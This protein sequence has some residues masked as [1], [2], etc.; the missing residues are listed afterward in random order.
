MILVDTALKKRAASGRP[1]LV[2]MA[3]AGFMGRGIASQIARHMPGLKLAAVY[4]RNPENARRACQEAGLSGIRAVEKLPDLRAA[5]ARGECAVTADAN[6]LCETP[7]I[8]VLIDATGAVEFGAQFAM[9]AIRHRKDLVLMNAELDGTVG[10]ILKWHAD[11]SGVVLTGCDGD[12]P[13]VQMNLVRFVESIGLKP[14][15][16]GNIKGLQDR[17]RNPTTQ[18]GFAKR[19]G[20]TPHMVT[21]FADGTKISFEQAIVANATGMRVAQRGML[22][23]THSGHVD[24]LTRKFD[25][26][27]LEA[28]GGIVEYVVGAQP[29]PGVFVFAARRDEKQKIYLDYG[30]LGEGPLYSFYVP[31]HLTVFEVPLS[32]ARVALFR[33]AVIAP[34]GGP[35]VDV[36]TTAKV[37]LKP[38]D[39]LD[40]LGG[41]LAYGQCENADVTRRERLLPVGLA[42]GCRLKRGIR[43]DEVIGYDDVELP[44]NRLVEQ[45]RAEQDERFFPATGA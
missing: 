34:L 11:R 2:G 21:S 4:S 15:V 22:G 37:D 33:D 32:A 31:Y 9:E 41:Y 1:I 16:C 14:L 27:E 3:G 25:V 23:Y 35:K 30:K 6:L 26:D 5:V 12:Q 13:G 38:G 45:L 7:E 19:W 20:Q 17:Y 18:A 43:R 29:S 36:V 8:D 39:V 28:M 42:E 10:P 40:G 24:E 44:G